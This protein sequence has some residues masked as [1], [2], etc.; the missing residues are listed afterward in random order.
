[1]FFISD[2][3][4][5]RSRNSQQ[6]RQSKEIKPKRVYSFKFSVRHVCAENGGVDKRDSI[7]NFRSKYIFSKELNKKF[8]PLW[9]VNFDC[10]QIVTSNST[11]ILTPKLGPSKST[12]S[13]AHVAAILE[14]KAR[15]F[16]HVPAIGVSTIHVWQRNCNSNTVT[17]T[18][19]N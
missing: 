11:L 2:T 12:Q 7:W 10:E 18:S 19:Q 3:I 4:Q 13:K 15:F 9:S 5:N 1:M 14:R 17:T 6:W 8:T 16:K